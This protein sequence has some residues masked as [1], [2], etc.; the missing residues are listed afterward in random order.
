MAATEK[1]IPATAHAVAAALAAYEAEVQLQCVRVLSGGLR[2]IPPTTELPL[3]CQGLL[4]MSPNSGPLLIRL[5][6]AHRALIREVLRPDRLH[7]T[8]LT[9]AR[10]HLAGILADVRSQLAALS[11]RDSSTRR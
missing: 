7:G 10:Q 9:E 6:G 8:E 1:P 4:R 3:L 2:R 11:S 5:V